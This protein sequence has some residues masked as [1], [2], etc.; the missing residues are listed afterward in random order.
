MN[1]TAFI[2]TIEQF[3]NYWKIMLFS[4]ILPRFRY[5]FERVLSDNNSNNNDELTLVHVKHMVLFGFEN[6]L[7]NCDHGKRS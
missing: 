2:E 1:R 5:L 7:I 4:T 3:L 6:N